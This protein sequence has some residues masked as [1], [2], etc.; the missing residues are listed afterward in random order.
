MRVGNESRRV[1]WVGKGMEFARRSTLTE[2]PQ[3]SASLPLCKMEM[4]IKPIS[5]DC[6]SMEDWIKKL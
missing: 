4:I 5:N 6:P 1:V 3:P 2:Q